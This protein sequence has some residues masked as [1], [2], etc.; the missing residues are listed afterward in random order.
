MLL[1]GWAGYPLK[2]ILGLFLL[3]WNMLV[4]CSSLGL[5]FHCHSLSHAVACFITWLG[6]I[7][8]RALFLL[9]GCVHWAVAAAAAAAGCYALSLSLSLARS[10]PTLLS[11]T[12]P[13]LCS[14]L[15]S[16]SSPPPLSHIL[17]RQKYLT[18]FKQMKKIPFSLSIFC[19]DFS[20]Y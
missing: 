12:L 20:K 1:S 10:L 5:L 13:P 8:A 14:A 3:L 6:E 4:M 15:L 7:C 11:L 16:Q 17:P 2:W 9:G 18:I 19:L